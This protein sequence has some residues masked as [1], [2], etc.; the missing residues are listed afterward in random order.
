MRSIGMDWLNRPLYDYYGAHGLS[1]KI[2]TMY[3][4]LAYLPQLKGYALTEGGFLTSDALKNYDQDQTIHY[5]LWWDV[6]TKP[7]AVT[8]L[9]ERIDRGTYTTLFEVNGYRFVKIKP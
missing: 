6:T 7:D 5:V 2:K 3:Q 9:Q 8:Y 4:P 1:G